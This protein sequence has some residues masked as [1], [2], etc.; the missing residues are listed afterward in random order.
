MERRRIPCDKLKLETF[1]KATTRYAF[2]VPIS[3]SVKSKPNRLQLMYRICLLLK[4]VIARITVMSLLS[5]VYDCR[6]CSDYGTDDTKID[7]TPDE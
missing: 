3:H 1:S 4:Y 5:S 6:D 7:E 2:N